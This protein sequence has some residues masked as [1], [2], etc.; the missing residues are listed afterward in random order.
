MP[1]GC[2]VD[3]RYQHQAQLYLERIGELI[4]AD[5]VGL[6]ALRARELA[7]SLLQPHGTTTLGNV[8]IRDAALIWFGGDRTLSELMEIARIE[9]FAIKML[10]WVFHFVG[11]GFGLLGMILSRKRWPVAA[12]VMGFALYTVVAHIVLLALPRYLFPV[13]VIWLIFAAVALVT[14]YDRLRRASARETA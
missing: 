4:G 8:S 11:I 1:A 12:P 14:V 7:Y 13:E 5:P 10:T 9:G 2:E 3:C 6:I